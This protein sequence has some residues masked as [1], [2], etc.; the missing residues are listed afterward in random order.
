V[1]ISTQYVGK[2]TELFELKKKTTNAIFWDNI[3]S[4]RCIYYLQNGT[5][6]T[7]IDQRVVKL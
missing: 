1:T 5:N 3:Y 2:I 4:E 7:E 6:F